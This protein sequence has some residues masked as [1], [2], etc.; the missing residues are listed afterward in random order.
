MEKKIMLKSVLT[1][2]VECM[3]L[4]DRYVMSG[5]PTIAIDYISKCKLLSEC[6]EDAGYAV[7]VKMES[8]EVTSGEYVG[9]KGNVFT[10]IKVYMP[11]DGSFTFT[12]KNV[13]E[14]KA[15]GFEQMSNNAMYHK[16]EYNRKEN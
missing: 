12:N 13:K 14:F 5:A 3:E 4:H 9:R 10:C 6:L 11:T 15:I 8:V 16:F 2:L 1:K 7:E